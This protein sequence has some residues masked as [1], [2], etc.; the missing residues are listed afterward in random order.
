MYK[1]SKKPPVK[2][3]FIPFAATL[4]HLREKSGKTPYAIA[5]RFPWE[6]QTPLD[7]IEDARRLP[8][9]TTIVRLVE[10]LGGTFAD[11]CLLLGLANYLPRT[12]I[13]ELAQIERQLTPLADEIRTCPYPVYILDRGFTFWVANPAAMMFIPSSV[14][15]DDLG[16]ML[17]MAFDLSFDSRLGLSSQI[18]NIEALRLEQVTRFKGLNIYS[19]HTSFYRSLPDFMRQRLSPKDYATFAEVWQTASIDRPG[20]MSVDVLG[21]IRMEIPGV[22]PLE[23]NYHADRLFFLGDLFEIVRFS[24]LPEPTNQKLAE[25]F[26]GHLKDTEQECFK[27]WQV[28]DAN[29]VLSRYA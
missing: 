29:S 1:T 17:P 23:F 28:T 18:A 16:K 2:E 19:Q 8:E 25:M 11:E 6:N 24:P 21:Y 15:I 9:P 20:S 12:R 5:K 10:C 27:I 7:L 26:F 13:P 22:A 14:Q 3:D 4:K